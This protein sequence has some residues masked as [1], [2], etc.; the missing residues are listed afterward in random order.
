M[1]V[2]AVQAIYSMGRGAHPPQEVG[3]NQLKQRRARSTKGVLKARAA[4]AA[5]LLEDVVRTPR[6]HLVAPICPLPFP[7]RSPGTMST[8]SP[9]ASSAKDGQPDRAL[10]GTRQDP[11]L[12]WEGRRE[13]LS[14]LRGGK[15][16]T[17]DL[18]RRTRPPGIYRAN[19]TRISPIT[20]R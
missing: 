6:R 14:P 11:S 8:A 3:E 12:C 7:G 10:P 18:S 2:A 9:L 15:L 16:V 4:T 20:P 5:E 17:R 1:K 19:P 13:G